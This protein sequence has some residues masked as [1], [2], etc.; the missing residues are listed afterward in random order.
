MGNVMDV[1]LIKRQKY[2]CLYL[3]YHF[4]NPTMKP[5]LTSIVILILAFSFKAQNQNISNGVVFDGEPYLV[6]DPA[7][8]QHLVAAWMGFQAGNK[9]T[10]KSSYSN[11]GGITWST[12]IWQAHQL[13]SN[14][15]ADV[16]LGYDLNGN[17]YMSYIDY[18]NVNFLNGAVYVRKSTNGGIS[19]GPA[20]EAISLL[21]CP[22][23]ACID[24]PWMAVDKSGGINDG[25]VYITSMN[26]DQPTLSF[27]PYHP[28]LSV[29]TD[30]GS[31]F[32]TPRFLDTLNFNAGSTITQPMPS[33]T[34]T[35]NGVFMA[36]YPAY[37]PINQ[38]AF[39]HL[40]IAKSTTAGVN[41]DHVDAYSG[42]GASISNPY[43]KKGS[44]FKSDPSDPNHVAFFTLKE[45]SGDVDIYFMESFDAGVNWSTQ[46]RINQDQLGNG[47]LQD[48]VW[49][50]FDQDGDLAIC[51]RDRRNA[52]SND[53]QTETEIYGVVR[54]KD[55]TNFSPDFPISNQLTPHDAVLEGSGNDFMNVNFLNDTIYAVWGDVRTG[56]LSIYINKVGVLNGTN[57]IH[58][59]SQEPTAGL[60]IF[61]NPSNEK[62][63]LSED[64]KIKQFTVH[65]SSGK[66]VLNG[67]NFPENGLR[68]THFEN[69]T[70]F[71]N[72]NL[73]GEVKVI[74]FVKE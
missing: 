51:W 52:S 5:A 66:E 21:D 73:D 18:D 72:I 31:S 19:W 53:Y 61:P 22:N 37:E 1:R 23:Q 7:N 11:D 14:G 39:A 8:S 9:I 63:F 69:G 64:L 49:A 45:T 34:V 74:P 15:S 60:S 54:W 46:Q 48:L 30:N 62:I 59:I 6:I 28:Y 43:L 27:P 42:G 13:A 26:A 3:L 68:I 29:S 44:L 41:I 36:I 67:R 40:Y 65:N 56:V 12:P 4:S 70:Y 38:G 32:S 20:V 47:K 58:L 57:S 50:D 17:L 35:S 71:L 16:S 2:N 55:S 10:I 33:P 25:T 24:R